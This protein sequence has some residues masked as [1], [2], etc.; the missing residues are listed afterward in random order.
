MKKATLLYALLLCVCCLACTGTVK[1]PTARTTLNALPAIFPD[2]A[3]VTIPPR[4]AP[5]RFQLAKPCDEAVAV[6]SCGNDKMITAASDGGKFLFP[7][8]EWND[9]LAKAVGKEIDV[10]IYRKTEGEWQVY[11]AFQWHVSTDPADDYLAYRLIEPGYELWNKMGIYQ[12]CL[13]DYE[14]TPIIENSL[15]NHNCMN[16]HSFCGQDPEKML[17]HMRAELPGTYI[18]SGNKVEKLNTKASE[19]VQS[20]VYPSWHPSGNF[21]A[22]SVNNT[23]QAFHRS[24]KNRVEVY[25]LSSDVVVYGVNKH[26][27]V[28]DSLLFSAKA[29]ETFPTFSPDGKTLYFCSAQARE[30]PKEFKSV[31]YNLCSISFDPETR[32]FGSRVDTLYSSEQATSQ[33]EGMAHK[34]ASFPRVSP[35]GKFLVFTLSAYGNFSIWH[36]DADLYMIDLRSGALHRM[37]ELNSEDVESYHSWSSNSRWLVFSSRR[38]DGLYTRPYLVHIDKD[39]KAGKPFVLP[40]EVPDFYPR[41]MY[42]YNI[43]EFVKGKVEVDAHDLA[44]TARK[45][46][47]RI[48]MCWRN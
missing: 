42:S 41:F 30:I 22:F 39:G 14:Q 40:Q 48:S 45:E 7:I 47:N 20:L 15:T 46:G 43:P 10:K 2:Y 13:V 4:I 31:E 23:R 26:E 37:D 18:I 17:F 16:C 27:V 44:A 3:N 8:R 32:R 38:G 34:S 12:R 24:D 9:L 29:F 21:V 11:P 33:K 5:L 1:E 35:D 25:D 36:K 28:T 19:K 6:L